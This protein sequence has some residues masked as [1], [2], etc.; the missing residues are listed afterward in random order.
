MTLMNISP[1][2]TVADIGAG[3]GYFVPH[4]SRAV[5]AKGTVLALDI[6]PDMVRF[7]T[8]RSASEKLDNVRPGL[9]EVAD[10]KLPAGA[11]DR[12]IIVNTW[13]HIPARTA[14]AAKLRAGLKPGGAVYIVDFTLETKSGPP[15]RHRLAPA[16][17]IAELEAGGLEA[18]LVTE[19]LPRQYVV[20][21]KRPL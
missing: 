14:Y 1:G 6:E 9:V 10:P 12:A 21:G 11:V 19:T 4:L 20:I 13:H 17:V 18:R 2:M 16:K 3:T 15:V 5:G 7:L 8:E